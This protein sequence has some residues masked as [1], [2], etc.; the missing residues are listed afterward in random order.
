MLAACDFVDEDYY[1]G[2][3]PPVTGLPK[4]VRGGAGT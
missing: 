2:E 3:A 4:L 1:V